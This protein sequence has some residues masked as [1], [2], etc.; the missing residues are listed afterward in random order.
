MNGQAGEDEGGMMFYRQ[1]ER[2][3]GLERRDG[4]HGLSPVLAGDSTC[5]HKALSR[6]GFQHITNSTQAAISRYGAAES[7]LGP[8]GNGWHY[9]SDSMRSALRM[10]SKVLLPFPFGLPYGEEKRKED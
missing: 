10:E 4:N 2:W 8:P 3:A 9:F 7:I 5:N 1:T 6:I